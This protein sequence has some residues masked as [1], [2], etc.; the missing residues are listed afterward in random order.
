MSKI[1]SGVFAIDPEHFDLG[2]ARRFLLRPGEA[3]GAGE[4]HRT[5]AACRRN[6]GEIVADK[7]ACKQILL[8]LLS[9][10][11]KFTPEGGRVTVS[12]R[13]EAAVVDIKCPTPAS[14]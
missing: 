5:A 3:E 12:A 2:R 6:I 1:E 4:E 14:A 11:V 8:N 9:N 7:R 10:A 13:R